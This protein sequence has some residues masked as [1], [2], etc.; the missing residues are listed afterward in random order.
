MLGQS[1]AKAP[2][3]STATALPSAGHAPSSELGAGGGAGETA[4][5]LLWLLMCS[6][7]HEN[8]GN[9]MRFVCDNAGF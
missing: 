6:K 5:R 1:V 2:G 4:G 7:Q 8:Y 9:K 3:T